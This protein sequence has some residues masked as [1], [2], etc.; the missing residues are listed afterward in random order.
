MSLHLFQSALSIHF[1]DLVFDFTTRE[2]KFRK[3]RTA[4]ISPDKTQDIPEVIAFVSGNDSLFLESRFQR[5]SNVNQTILI[6]L[7]SLYRWSGG[8]VTGRA[9]ITSTPPLFLRFS[10]NFLATTPND[11]QTGKSGIFL[12]LEN[13]GHEMESTKR[14]KW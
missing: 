7:D 11:S 5:E 3:N 6:T 13:D 12:V 2:R 8:H 10:K 14:T 9:S 4:N 1:Y